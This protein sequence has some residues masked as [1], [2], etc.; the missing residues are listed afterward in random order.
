[1]SSGAFFAVLRRGQT[2][3]AMARYKNDHH[4]KTHGA[5][6]DAASKL[7]REHGFTDTSVANVMKAVGLTHGG[8]Y[9]H[10]PDKTAMLVAAVERAFVQSPKNF[11]VLTRMANA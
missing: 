3:K 2:R 6:V 9:A 4:G 11:D 7:L 5:I 8:F 10:F 1:M